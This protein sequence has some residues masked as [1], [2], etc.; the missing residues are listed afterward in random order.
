MR[1]FCAL[2][3]I[4]LSL[5]SGIHGINV[6]GEIIRNEIFSAKDWNISTEDVTISSI[7]GEEASFY[8]DKS[9]TV[10]EIFS[11]DFHYLPKGLEK[12]FPNIKLLSIIN[13]ELESVKSDDL[14]PFVHLTM[15][16]LNG[17]KITTLDSNVFEFNPEITILKIVFNDKLKHIGADILTPLKKLQDADFSRNGC[18][19]NFVSN[20]G[21]PKPNFSPLVNDFKANCA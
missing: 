20:N 14:K 11:R 15:V 6:E 8:S 21:L 10:L 16:N 7:N 5:C 19:D 12:F 18:V 13:T 4:T 2:F 17:N 3:V 9:I 1:T